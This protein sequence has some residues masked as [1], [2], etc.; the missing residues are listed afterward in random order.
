MTQVANDT[1]QYK[2]EALNFLE[3]LLLETKTGEPGQ[4]PTDNLPPE[5]NTPSNSAIGKDLPKLQAGELS[6][7]KVSLEILLEAIGEKE[8]KTELKAGIEQ[9]KAN[10]DRKAEENKKILEKAKENLEKLESAGIWDKVKTAFAWIGAIAAVVVSAALV[11]TGAGA[12]AVAGLVVACVALANQALDTVGTAVN[13]QG[14]GLTS[15]AAKGLSKIFGPESEQWIKFGLDMALAIASIALSCGSSAGSAANAA[16][17][18]AEGASVATKVAKAGSAV[19]SA[20]QIASAASGIASSVY[21]YQ[22]VSAQADQKK[23]QAILEQIQ[24]MNELIT[25]HLE[26]TVKDG[27]KITDTVTE[28]VKENAAVQTAIMTNSAGPS[29]MA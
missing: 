28:I 24:M 5:G 9:V 12:F 29:G 20:T 3:Q 2:Q 8:R 10:T 18:A 23:L 1:N 16:S 14:W 6:Q 27:E 7:L 4:I 17:K 22:A 11:A 25:K 19:Q 13:G 21:T 15:L 26:N